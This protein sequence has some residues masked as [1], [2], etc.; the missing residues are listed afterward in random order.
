MKKNILLLVMLLL[1]I[2]VHGRD[3]SNPDLRNQPFSFRET[4]GQIRDQQGKIRT[5]IDFIMQT[6]DL[7]LYIG[8]GQ[9]HYQFIKPAPADT[10]T[11]SKTNTPK[12]YRV[13]GGMTMYRL[14]VNL[15]NSNKNVSAFPEEPVRER[16]CYYNNP[17]SN[18]KGTTDVHVYK[19]IVYKN[20]YP[21]I[22]WVLYTNGKGFKYDFV[23][24]PGAKVSDIQLKY[25]GTTSMKLASNGSLYIVT[26]LG[27][28]TEETPYS[29]EAGSKK[30]VTST[31]I[32]KDNM[33]SFKTGAYKNTLVIDPGVKWGTYFGG[34]GWPK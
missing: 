1:Q 26:P 24:H 8:K 9:L 21:G 32:L 28:L 20:I 22:D 17:D 2:V 12:S 30:M 6:P 3:G 27:S 4:K 23:V 15:V 14:D 29:Y 5:D 34:T 16:H 7:T 19:K 13:P 10:T 18:T 25:D 31:F 11:Y 33:V